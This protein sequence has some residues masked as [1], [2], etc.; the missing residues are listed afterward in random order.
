M[1]LNSECKRDRYR[2]VDNM[3]IAT[4]VKKHIAVILTALPVEYNAVRNHL[5]YIE[6][7]VHPKGTIYEKG[8][9]S[10]NEQSMEIGIAEIG[11]GNEQTALEVERA[12]QYFN[13]SI[14]LFVGVA[15]GVK[16]DVKLGDV[17][18]ASKVY[19]YESGKA[20]DTFKPR[21]QVI[22]PNYKMIN[23]ARAESRKNDWLQHL[24]GLVPNP[25]PTVFVKP[26]AAGGKVLNSS[27]SEAYKLIKS[28][29]EDTL[30]V[31]MEGY[32][33]LKAAYANPQ[34]D[35]L[36]I[37]GISDLIDN[38]DK[39]DKAGFQKTA[40]RHASAFAFEVLA[41]LYFEP[42]QNTGANNP[43]VESDIQNSE[44]V[45][46]N[47]VEQKQREE[48]KRRTE[49]EELER[50]KR[51]TFTSPYTGMEFVLIPSGKFMMGSPS[52]E[53]GSSDDESPARDVI[54][55]NSFFM[56]KYPVTQKQ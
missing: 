14:I 29:Y 55:K 7:K 27:I 35:A 51:E 30:A 4:E 38:K 40:S 48:A 33:F 26:I 39:A 16:D 19:G 13:P 42:I 43:F 20:G 2:Y 37:R 41:K 31:E 54:I 52:D 12:I 15:G 32:G 8:I 25:H 6:E 36:V 53:K 56:G 22:L 5:K 44:L 3:P 47:I 50:K 11:E 23:R 10:S 49:K 46:T 17:V 18:V 9:F 1:F 34:V 21:P 28:D 24:D 45:L